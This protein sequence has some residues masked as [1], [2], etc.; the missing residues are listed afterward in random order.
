[1]P[2]S[3]FCT[4]SWKS[5][6]SKQPNAEV[7]ESIAEVRGKQTE[8]DEVE[9]LNAKVKGLTAKIQEMQIES[10]K[11]EE[12]RILLEQ[13][14]RHSVYGIWTKGGILFYSGQSTFEKANRIRVHVVSALNEDSVGS[15]FQPFHAKLLEELNGEG[16]YIGILEE[17]LNELQADDQEYFHIVNVLR[18]FPDLE[19]NEKGGRVSRRIS[20]LTIPERE[21]E[22]KKAEET[23]KA[24]F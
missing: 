2:K 24:A 13:L 16:I 1:M 20:Q 11:A 7:K 9:A 22:V 21:K 10:D 4:L 3:E 23:A 14:S 15:N 19:G 6:E 18:Q 12:R 8:S 17:K 5:R